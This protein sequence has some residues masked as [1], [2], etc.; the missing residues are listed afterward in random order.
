MDGGKGQG[1]LTVAQTGLLARHHGRRR[2]R[3]WTVAVRVER[4][5]GGYR[6][7]GDWAGVAA[8]NAFLGHL[9]A[10]A[11]APATVR[12][13]A[14]DLLNFARFAAERRL[15]LDDVVPTDIFDWLDWQRPPRRRA[16]TVVAFAARDG[17]AP[18]S[19]NRRA[20]ALRA[21]FEHQVLA[22]ARASNPVPAPRRGAGLRPKARG[23]LGHLG[24]GRTRG[25]GRLVRQSRQLPESL[26]PADV[27]AF[28]A[29]LATHRDRAIVLAM[30][31]GGLR[32][33][34]VRG[35]RLAGVD[36]GRHRVRVLGKGGRERI[37]PIDRA[38]FAELAAYLRTERPPGLAT[39]ECFV[40]LR[41]PTAGSPLSEAGLRS[42]FRHHRAR[43]GALR[44]RPHR[45]RHTYGTELA[46]AGIDL[47]VLRELMGHA[48]PETT[49]AYVH[50]S[51]DHLAAEYRAAREAIDR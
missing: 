49:A 43:S 20:A 1:C 35:L 9:E 19:V 23:P 48:S 25:G 33:G 17:A 4:R 32:A 2:K 30:V 39:P 45:L 12:A 44:V 31:L 15:A 24:P 37:V 11:F 34:E 50:L 51:A 16:G 38:F 28:L 10:R 26:D 13:Y 27:G 21:F 3:R 47:L 36:Q 8:A 6:L 41:G 29:D 22:G 42:L 18:A 40:V 5:D 7:A 46:A 14:Y